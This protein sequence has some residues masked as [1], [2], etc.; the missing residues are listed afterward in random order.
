MRR[1]LR[2]RPRCPGT[3]DSP[4]GTPSR[5]TGASRPA[6]PRESSCSARSGTRVPHA[7]RQVPQARL[8]A[9]TAWWP[10]IATRSA[11]LCRTVPHR[12]DIRSSA[13]DRSHHVS[14]DEQ[15]PVCVVLGRVEDSAA[16]AFEPGD[17]RDPY[18]QISGNRVHLTVSGLF[19]DDPFRVAYG[20]DPA[21][22]SHCPFTARSVTTVEPGIRDAPL[23]EVPAGGTAPWPVT[24][25]CPRIPIAACD[26]GPADEE[27]HASPAVAHALDDGASATR[28]PSLWA[29]GQRGPHGLN[30]P[31]SSSR[32]SELLAVSLK[33]LR[34]LGRA[35]AVDE[36]W[37][38]IRSTG[39]R[40]N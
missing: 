6:E 14:S 3:S 29:A 1:Q 40:R 33:D 23:A 30:C 17:R 37:S 38:R 25:M 16:N 15:H 34:H 8:S 20:I 10:S 26:Q 32:H 36:S 5:P 18:R 35:R 31:D 28:L 2:S 19:D 24:R 13:R 9:C 7:P 21:E 4:P 12:G 39:K 27:G 22:S 11:A